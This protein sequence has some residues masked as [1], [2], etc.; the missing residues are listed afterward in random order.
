ML[1]LTQEELAEAAGVSL[2]TVNLIENAKQEGYRGLTLSAISRALGWRSDGADL[3]VRGVIEWPAGQLDFDN[4]DQLLLDPAK[5][6][7]G[8]ARLVIDS[9]DGRRFVDDR[10]LPDQAEEQLIEDAQRAR[11]IFISAKGTDLDELQRLDPDSYEL[12]MGMAQQALERARQRR[13]PEDH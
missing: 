12:L 5:D 11:R 7:S 10:V 4:V 9:D 1:G 13:D 8:A 6:A 2:S 3:I